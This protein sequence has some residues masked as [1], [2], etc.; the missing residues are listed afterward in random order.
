MTMKPQQDKMAFISARLKKTKLEDVE[1]E[2]CG[3]DKWNDLTVTS[4]TN[5][6]RLFLKCRIPLALEP[7][8]LL[9]LPDM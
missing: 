2:K 1:M 3:M 8:N 6:D 4:G 9:H 7:Q 5:R